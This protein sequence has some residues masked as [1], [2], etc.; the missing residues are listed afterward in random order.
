MSGIS[1]ADGFAGGDGSEMDP[2]K[3]A[4]K[5]QLQSINDPANLDSYFILI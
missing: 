5:E 1:L 3:I 2:Y 4:T